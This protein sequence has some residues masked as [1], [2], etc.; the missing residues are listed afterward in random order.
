MNERGPDTGN[1]FR[2]GVNPDV[3]IAGGPGNAVDGDRVGSDHQETGPGRRASARTSLKSSFA[4]STFRGRQPADRSVFTF[5]LR[6]GFARSGTMLDRE[7]PHHRE[8]LF[9][10]GRPAEVIPGLVPVG[11]CAR[12]SPAAR[13]PLRIARNLSIESPSGDSTGGPGRGRSRA[14]VSRVTTGFGGGAVEPRGPREDA[15]PPPPISA[16]PRPR[17]RRVPGGGD[18]PG[19]AVVRSSFPVSRWQAAIWSLSSRISEGS[20]DAQTDSA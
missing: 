12:A 19:A 6:H 3:E 14:P 7:R 15:G 10:G 9:R 4:T 5:V 1:V 20:S 18:Y 13:A 16:A 8:A 17:C 2:A 11:A